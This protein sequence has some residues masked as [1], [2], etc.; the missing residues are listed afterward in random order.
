MLTCVNARADDTCPAGKYINADNECVNCNVVVQDAHWCPGNGERKPCPNPDINYQKYVPDDHTWVVGRGWPWAPINATKESQ[1]HKDTYFNTVGGQYF[2]GC[3][4]NG[5]DYWCDDVFYQYVNVGYYLANWKRV[6]NGTHLYYTVK[7]CTNAPAHSHYTGSGT[8]DDPD[9]AFRD[10][11]DCPWEC[12]CGYERA[13]D[14]CVAAP[15]CTAGFTTLRSDTG[16]IAKLYAA[17]MSWPAIVVS[18]NGKNCYACLES[19]VSDNAF[20]LEYDGKTYHTIN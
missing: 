20:N 13:G 12:D 14:E 10:K 15:A 6:V 11:N 7:A 16:V 8:P 2:V 18:Y 1:C 9:G 17:Q 5:Y 4:Y 3:D 19:G